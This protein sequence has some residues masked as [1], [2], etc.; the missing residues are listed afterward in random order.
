MEYCTRRNEILQYTTMWM[1]LRNIMFKG[2]SQPQKSIHF[3]S[4][5]YMKF[6]NR[7]KKPQQFIVLEEERV[8]NFGEKGFDKE[9]VQDDLLGS[10]LRKFCSSLL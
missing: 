2:K 6:K 7:K 4:F 8:V 3:I 5:Q 9:I 10:R 1:N